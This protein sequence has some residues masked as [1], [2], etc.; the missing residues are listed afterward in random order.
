MVVSEPIYGDR[1]KVVYEESYYAERGDNGRAEDPWL[2]VVLCQNG[3][4]YP[5]G[6]D[7]LVASTKSR[8]AV[9]KQL[10]GLEFAIL[11]KDGADG[12]DV[13][14]PVDRFE[15]IEGV[16]V[17]IEDRKPLKETFKKHLELESESLNRANSVLR[18]QWVDETPGLKNLIQMWRDDEKR[19]HEGLKKIISKPFIR[20]ASN[21]MITIFR[22]EEFLEERYRKSKEYWDKQSN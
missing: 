20:M 22:G 8:G 16:D 4:I 18:R 6:D 15:V 1:F 3:E 12:S 9:A 5:Y 14:F 10:Q 11:H 2:M 13:I 19:H 17:F 7:Q 21:D